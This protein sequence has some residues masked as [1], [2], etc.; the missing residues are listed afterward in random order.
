MRA[1]NLKPGFFK[2]ENLAE[3]G[4]YA[5][6][7]YEGLWL[8]ADREGRME[9]R[10]KRIQA[11]IFPYFHDQPVN[12]LLDSL[13]KAGFILRYSGF[14]CIPAWRKHQNPHIKEAASTIP[15]PDSHQTGTSVARLNPSS[16]NPES[17]ILNPAA[18]SSWP[19][20]AA[21]I[22][23]TFPETGDKLVARIIGNALLKDE[24]LSDEQIADL[25]RYA[26]RRKRSVQKSPGLFLE[27]VTEEYER[28]RVG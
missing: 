10:P 25:V 3:L 28:W 27:S 7:L 9:D 6:L 2:N 20:A 24:D 11:E 16:L 8:L 18:S 13:A 17:G 15:A 23:E 21:A 1:R 5:M 4:P 14:I 26:Y 12:E 22:R 19:L